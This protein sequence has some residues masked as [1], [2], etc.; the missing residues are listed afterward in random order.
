M[1]R[2]L[3]AAVCERAEE[4]LDQG[5]NGPYP[6]S[7][8]AAWA[9]AFDR[10][11]A[12]DPAM[13]DLL[14]LIAWCAPEPVPLSLLIQ[15]PEV[16]PE[17]LRQTA[18]DPLVFT[19]CTRLLHRRG[20]TAVAPRSVRLHR[21]PAVLLRARTRDELRES[22]GW[23]A[24]I[25]RTLRAVAPPNPWKNPAVWPRWQQLLPHVLAAT[26]ASRSLDPVVD[27]VAWLLD[28]AAHYRDTRGEPRAALP[29]ARRAHTLY[30]DRLGADHPDTL[31]SASNLA[32]R[33]SG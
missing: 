15:H 28:Y 31:G 2:H 5:H 23:D 21:V 29:L 10:L 27:Q 12:D 14:T 9:M 33:F 11:A 22:G 18:A 25:V 8:T 4:L 26:D 6:L 1:H 3:P 30:R 16:L 20:M 19:P 13:L 24:A 17:R 7:V 32:R